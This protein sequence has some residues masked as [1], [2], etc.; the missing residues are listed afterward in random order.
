MALASPGKTARE[1]RF[2]AL[3]PLLALAGGVAST[4]AANTALA[5]D[6]LDLIPDYQLFGLFGAG[7]GLGMLWIMLIGFVLLIFPLNALIFQP[8]FRALDARAE[9]IQGARDQSN[10]LEQD[11]DSVLERYETAIREARADSEEARQTQ[12]A[13]AR[14]EQ[15]ALTGEARTTAEDELERARADLNQSL[16]EARATLRASAD[17]LATAAAEQI[18]GRPLS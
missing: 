14:E 13:G 6:T 10:Q 2:A 16:E 4:F 7:E 11:A 1:L 8:I 12:L 17:D 5:S 9:R 3:T 15:A 18:L